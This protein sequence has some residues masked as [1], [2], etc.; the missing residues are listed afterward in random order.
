MTAAMIGRLT[1]AAPWGVVRLVVII[2]VLIFRPG[3]LFGR[4]AVLRV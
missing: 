3:G 2:V 4:T 1:F